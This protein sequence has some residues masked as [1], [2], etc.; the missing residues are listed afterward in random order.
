M[1]RMIPRAL[2]ATILILGSLSQSGCIAVGRGDSYTTPTLG[3]QLQ[4][5]KSARDNGAMTDAEYQEAKTRV[6][7]G[8][9]LAY[10]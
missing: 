9:H 6:L 8:E 4:D 7:R 10:R 1:S 3:K 2:F 5:L